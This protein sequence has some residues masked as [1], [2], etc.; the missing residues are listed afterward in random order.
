VTG[1]A[2]AAANAPLVARAYARFKA[3]GP[4]M[5]TSQ[6]SHFLREDA[7]LA[8]TLEPAVREAALEECIAPVMRLAAGDW[9]GQPDGSPRDGIGLLVLD[10]LL[11]RRVGVDNRY[12]AEL[13]GDGDLLR[14]WQGE[15]IETTVPH[16]TGWRVLTPARLAV[17]D[18]RVTRRIA[19]YPELT[20]RF[21][22][23]A[24]ER[25]RN[26]AVNMAIVHQTRIDVRLRI[27]L[28]HLAD[29]W[30]KVNPDGII[31]PLSLSH[32]TLAELVAARRPT[33]TTALTELERRGLVRRIKAGWLLAGERPLELSELR[34]VPA[35]SRPPEPHSG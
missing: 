15:G 28:W 33:V 19:R 14:P 10:G 2:A 7:D 21:V 11:L 35:L 9:D 27:L 17:L 24:L 12:G 1:D 23:R 22:G 29:R 4:P 20:G 18:L 3:M 26:L 30:G 25:S 34:E 8:A 32:A 5:P 31:L 6:I 13:L 16:T